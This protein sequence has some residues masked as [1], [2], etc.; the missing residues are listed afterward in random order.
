MTTTHLGVIQEYKLPDKNKS[1]EDLEQRVWNR[2]RVG[3]LG[4]SDTPL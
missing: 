1:G 4:S 3:R 2:Y